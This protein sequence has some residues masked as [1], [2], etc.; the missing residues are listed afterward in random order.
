MKQERGSISLRT[1]VGVATICV[2][3]MVLIVRHSTAQGGA[4]DQLTAQTVAGPAIE[5]SAPPVA[6][7]AATPAVAVDTHALEA[8]R[9]ARRAHDAAQIA[10]LLDQWSVA[11]NKALAT[12]PEGLQSRIEELQEIRQRF[13]QL[14][15]TEACA[16]RAQHVDGDAMDAHITYFIAVMDH[17]PTVPERRQKAEQAES[18]AK[19]AS[20]GCN[21]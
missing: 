1:L 21:V 13:A 9:Q 4:A 7:A 12:P 8:A 20:A 10:P 17:W 11:D 5:T 2:G 6:D 19:A 16:V 15:V 18:A 3:L 14:P